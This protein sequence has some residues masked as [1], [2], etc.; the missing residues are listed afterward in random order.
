MPGMWVEQ[1]VPV[2]V[3]LQEQGSGSGLRTGCGSKSGSR[4]AEAMS[5]LVGLWGAGA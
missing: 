1:V 2:P 5:G 3:L 4:W